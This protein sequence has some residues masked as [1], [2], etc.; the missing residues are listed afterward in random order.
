MNFEKFIQRILF[1]NGIPLYTRELLLCLINHLFVFI[2][3]CYLYFLYCS[4]MEN[5]FYILKET[6]TK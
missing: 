1:P 6:N 2:L 3:F 5:K 4:I